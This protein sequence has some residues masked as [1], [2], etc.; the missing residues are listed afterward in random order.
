MEFIPK[1][2]LGHNF[3]ELEA[4]REPKHLLYLEIRSFVV[5]TMIINFDAVM[6]TSV[7]TNC[8]Y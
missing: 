6:V 7:L 4:Q 2:Y 8:Q 3:L 1:L 5:K